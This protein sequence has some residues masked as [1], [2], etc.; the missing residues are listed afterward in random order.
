MFC[1]LLEN[2][3]DFRQL[4]HSLQQLFSKHLEFKVIYLSQITNKF[5]VERLI[6]S[7]MHGSSLT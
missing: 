3:F 1:I 5:V 2:T 6:P 7:C 4:C